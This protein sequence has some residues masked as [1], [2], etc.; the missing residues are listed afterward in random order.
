MYGGT[1]YACKLAGGVGQH[2]LI[3]LQQSGKLSMRRNDTQNKSLKMKFLH[4]TES[5]FHI[6]YPI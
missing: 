1:N 6:A 5:V 2:S 4:E 3:R